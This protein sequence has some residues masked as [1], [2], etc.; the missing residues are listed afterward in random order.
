MASSYI[1]YT[2]DGSQTD[3]TVTFPYLDVDHVHFYVDGTE[4]TT[5]ISWPSAGVIRATPAVASASVIRIER[6]T[7]NT[8]LVNFENRNNLTADNLSTAALQAIYRAVESYDRSEESITTN[9]AGVFDFQG[10]RA[11]NVGDPVNPS[12]LVSKAYA[13]TVINT[14][15]T[16]ATNATNAANT[17][18]TAANTASTKA[19][20]ATTAATNAQAS[21]DQAAADVASVDPANI[22]HQD[23]NLADL[24]DKPTAVTNLGLKPVGTGADLMAGTPDKLVDTNS[25]NFAL[26]YGTLG[27]VSGNVTPDFTGFVNVTM[28]LTGNTVLKF[29]TVD[30]TPVLGRSG[31]IEVVMDGTGGW[32]LGYDTGADPSYK[33]DNAVLISPDTGAGRITK[34]A[35][36]IRS[37]GS[38]EL[39]QTGKGVR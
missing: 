17:A 35:Y 18:T 5:G 15:Q 38:I 21:A 28:T 30:L 34:I 1:E 10:R 12:D 11:A 29:P 37:T 24:R 23:Q 39:Y 3:W 6:Q 2:G 20:A 4:V 36:H 27:N 13:D 26:A 32:T 31:L 22:V 33:F 14:A 19:D 16:A 25:V 8:A 9:N 7:P